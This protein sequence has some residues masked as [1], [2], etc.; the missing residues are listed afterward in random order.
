MKTLKITTHWT[1]EQ[2][3]VNTAPNP[4]L[5][6]AEHKNQIFPCKKVLFQKNNEH[7]EKVIN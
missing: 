7:P 2:A 6:A 4:P 5:F 3:D 1:P